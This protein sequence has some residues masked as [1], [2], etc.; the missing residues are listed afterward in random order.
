MKTNPEAR[1]VAERGASRPS[2]PPPLVDERGR[3]DLALVWSGL[4]GFLG[5]LTST[6]HK[7]VAKRYIVT[8]M[9]FFLMGGI[10]AL[11]MRTQLARPENHFLNPDLYNQIFT[12]HGSNMMFLFAVPVMEAFALYLLPL[13]IGTRNVALPRLNAYGYWV[14][15]G[16]GLLLWVALFFNSAPDVGWFAYPPL[17]SSYGIGKR[18][19][20]WAQLVTFTEI[21]A[22]VAAVEVVVTV[23]KLR[24]PG[25]SLA[26]MPLFVWA[27][28]VTAFMIIF[29][30][31]AVMLAS[32]NFLAADR[33]VSTQFL[34]PAEGGDVLLWQH[35]F[36][37]FGHPEVYIM[38][39]PGLG[40][41]SMIVSTFAR[42]QIFGY[43][44]MVVSLI[45]TGFIGFGL[46]VHHMFATGLPQIGESFFTAASLMIAIPSG[47]QI[48]CWIATLWSGRPVWKTPLLWIAGFFF[49]FVLG[50]LSGVVIASVP[51]DWQLHDTFFIVAHFHYV[52]IG[53]VVFPLFA[54]I[55]YWFPK[56]T[57]RMLSERLGKVNF[58]TF[59]VGFNVTFFPMHFLG[60][61]GMPRRVYTYLPETGWGPLNLLATLGAFLLAVSVILFLVNVAI[62]WRGGEPA[63]DDPWGGESL[64]WATSSPPPPYNFLHI[65]VATARA[66]LWH[67]Q[68]RGGERP[69]VTGLRTDRREVL[70]TSTLDAIP[71]HRYNIPGPTIWPF[72]LGVAT[73]IT[74]IGVIFNV[75]ALLLGFVLN[76]LALLGWFWSSKGKRSSFVGGLWGPVEEKP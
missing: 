25:M 3:A 76:G 21:A 39:I 30:M 71:D 44:A 69:V 54:G 2:A 49:V 19:D 23:V 33:A 46:W 10:L 12:T 20:I 75:K 64:E 56:I 36:W 59:L 43:P 7:S 9:V 38:F 31:P 68:A 27:M 29:A 72:V 11:L 8:T 17:S 32:N 48:F 45:A 5:W 66:P 40:M 58:W 4:P 51:L 62:S 60:I 15:L 70:V 61:M 28:L 52:I 16:G 35:M 65:P 1:R 74:W 53:G 63:G 42:R 22:L 13:M 57:G 47:V 55:Y 24:A 37:F 73:G 18:P 67:W 6:N 41:V 34:N 50:G 14:F 26:R